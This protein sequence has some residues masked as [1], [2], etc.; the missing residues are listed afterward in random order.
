MERIFPA[1]LL[2]TGKFKV[3]FLIAMDLYILPDISF[4]NLKNILL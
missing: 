4:Y 1:G 3:L 2:I